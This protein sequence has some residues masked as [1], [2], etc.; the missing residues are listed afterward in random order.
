MYTLYILFL[1][2]RCLLLVACCPE[3]V[4]FAYWQ[5]VYNFEDPRKLNQSQTDN[6]RDWV[7]VTGCGAQGSGLRTQDSGH[8]TQGKNTDY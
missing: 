3:I 8:R 4:Q 5:I 7:L 6:F 1:V 2:A